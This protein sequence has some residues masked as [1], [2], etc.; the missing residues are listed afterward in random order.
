MTTSSDQFPYVWAC[1]VLCV[2]YTI[3]KLLRFGRREKH[4]PPGPPT[5]SIVGNAHL[6]VDKNLYKKFKHW[7]EIYGLIYSL[8][9]GKGTMIVLNSRR[10][11]YDLIDKRSAIYSGRPDEEQYR[12][13]LKGENIA[14][15]DADEKWRAQR[16]VMARFFAPAKLDGGLGGVLEA[17]VITL[18]HDL[19]V[20]PEDFS[21]HVQRSTASFSSIA[22]FGQRAKSHDDFWATGVYKAMDILNAAIS[23]GTYLPSE[24]F[25]IF[26]L[27][28]KRWNPAHTRAEQ[29][30]TSIT[31]IWLDA[32]KRVESRR[33]HGDTRESLM[34]QL[35]D[36]DADREEAFSGT[37]LANFVG[38]LMQ[39][40]AETSALALRTN[41]MFLATHPWVQ[42]RA[43][44]ELDR[45]CGAERVPGFADFG[46]LPYVN[47][48]VK[49]GL[50][51]RPV[52]PTGIP[53]RCTQDNWYEGMLIPKDATIIIPHYSLSHTQFFDPSSYN[54]DRYLSHPGLAT[55]YASAPDYQ[56]RDHYSYGA[57][58]RIC[59]GMHLAERMQ[60]RMVAALLWAFRIEHAVDEVTGEVME[61]DTE[62]F[63][64]RLIAGPK[65]FKCRFVLRSERHGEIV[66]REMER[67]GG[68]LEGWE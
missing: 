11:V 3:I 36:E 65:E 22:L 59:A 15:M 24:Q 8:K 19:L 12:T 60:W 16:K 7:S 13:A 51:I 28:P 47:C 37:K 64:E 6:A 63:E 10:A 30:F 40:A 44:R 1:T 29:C 54:P 31:S 67:V 27:L 46:E 58:R 43:Q 21:K 32:Q 35:L 26:K 5:Y 17:E 55:E 52:V 38:A 56:N 68:M 48:I 49:E 50:R 45:V 53:H 18:M 66:R 9:I 41:I 23:P 20:S 25:P 2:T 4:L 61:I 33:A 57:G 62:A 39:A 34:D 14:N 42:R